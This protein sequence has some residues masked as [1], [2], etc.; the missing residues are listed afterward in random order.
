MLV[1]ITEAKAKLGELS[2]VAADED[3]VVVR[4]GHPSAVI[5]GSER[6][7]ALLDEM[8]DLKD[9]LSVYES[10]ESDPSLRIS[11]DKA[12]AELGVG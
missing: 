8:E 6:Y 4:H 1:T 3:V 5:V 9:R 7:E 10:A 12:R 11:L 2:R